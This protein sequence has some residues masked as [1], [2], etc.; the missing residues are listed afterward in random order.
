MPSETTQSTPG[1]SNGSSRP[2]T[3]N[4][5]GQGR[6]PQHSSKGQ[7]RWHRKRFP[8]WWDGLRPTTRLRENSTQSRRTKG[9]GVTRRPSGR[10]RGGRSGTASRTPA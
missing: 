9:S 8:D 10:R 4:R 3:W 1:S 2:G 5:Q 6:S 7:T